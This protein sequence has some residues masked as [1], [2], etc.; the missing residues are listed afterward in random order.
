M[1]LEA[2][3]D[4]K[5]GAAGLALIKEFEGYHK[6]LPNGDCE[7]YLDKVPAKPIWTIGYGCTEGVYKGMRLTEAQ[8]SKL[9][10][11]ELVKHEAFVKEIV[12]VSLDQNEFDALVSFSYNLGPGNL[13]K[14][15]ENR[16]NKG[17][18]TA[19]AN[20]IPLYN[21]A[22]GKSA[23]VNGLARRRQAEKALFLKW[24]PKDVAETKTGTLVTRF[25][26]WFASL[27]IGTALSWNFLTDVRQ[28]MNDHAGW[29]V[30]GAGAALF[31]TY[32]TILWSMNNNHPEFIP[33]DKE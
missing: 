26:N 28:F 3:K 11:G 8:A 32:K 30:L 7:A 21:Q 14:L 25:Q 12:T 20:A 13:R 31:L 27:G 10:Q 5:L 23:K 9:F 29:L 33:E 16:L 2:N 15:V 4:L 1:I 24:T 17:N 22:K 6:K 19:T 18:R